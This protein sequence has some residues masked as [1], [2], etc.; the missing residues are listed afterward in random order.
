[1]V[2]E[3]DGEWTSHELG[4]P[5][6]HFGRG[7]MKAGKW[8]IARTQLRSGPVVGRFNKGGKRMLAV[9]L[10]GRKSVSKAGSIEVLKKPAAGV[11][12]EWIKGEVGSDPPEGA[13]IGG[14]KRDGTPLYIVESGGMPGYYDSSKGCVRVWPAKPACVTDFSYLAFTS[15]GKYGTILYC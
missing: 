3:V 14:E 8:L 13:V 11:T 4:E 10:T 2:T 12:V 15:S 6:K 7:Y 5:S 1:M 9:T